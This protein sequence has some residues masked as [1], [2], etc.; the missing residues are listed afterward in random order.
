MAEAPASARAGLWC[1]R[2]PRA[3][4][5]AGRC[6]GRTDLA[7]DPRRAKRLAHR[8]RDAARRHGLPRVVWVSPLI[9]TRAVG[10]WLRRWGWRVETDARLAELDF[11]AWDGRPWSQIPWAEVEAWCAD[12]L[13]CAPGG[14]ETLAQLSL[15]VQAFE[16]DAAGAGRG[17]RLVV[18]HAGWINAWLA[19]APGCTR[20]E[21]ADWPPPPPQGALRRRADGG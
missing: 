1:W 12:L 5:A 21:A 20:L 6:I 10:L 2:H 14:G 13:H 15:R 3:R 18:G 16:A 17:P 7:V 9:R 11:G 19:V 8:I 4:G